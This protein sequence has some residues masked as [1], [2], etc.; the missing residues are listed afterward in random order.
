MQAL[1]VLRTLLENLPLRLEG[2]PRD[3]VLRK[4]A[5]DRWSAQE[6]LGHLLDSA[7]NN[8]QRIVRAQLEDKP[9]MPGYDGNRWVALHG[10]QQRDWREMVAVWHALNEQLLAA[11]TA[12]S[13]AGW[14][15]TCTIGG[16]APVTLAFVFEDYVHHM[17]HHLRH[18][19]VEL[20][21]LLSS[22][23]ALR[24]AWKSW[25]EGKPPVHEP[26]QD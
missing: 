25:P 2:L 6:E 16:S 19:E 5:P 8:H 22:L 4:S 13:E 24:G 15:R 21:D 17:V 23:P 14:H 12:V 1:N 9:A 18:I 3:H 11:A 20:D 7:A 10:Y 26:A